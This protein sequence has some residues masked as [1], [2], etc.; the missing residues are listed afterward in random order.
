MTM[1]QR[2]VVGG[3]SARC[4]KA[5]RAG[6]NCHDEHVGHSMLEDLELADGL[7]ELGSRLQIFESR[8]IERVDDADGFGA[9]G[10]YAE[11][12]RFLD[13]GETFAALADESIFLDEDI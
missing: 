9:Q 1:P 13:D 6:L 8:L 7:A 2:C 10:G 12:E 3:A 5:H 11:V 4:Q